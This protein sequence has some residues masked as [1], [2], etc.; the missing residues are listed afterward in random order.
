MNEKN[1]WE[2]YTSQRGAEAT[3]CPDP[4]ELA[5][6]ID[7]LLDPEARDAIEAHLSRC[8]LCLASVM[9][10][11]TH[12]STNPTDPIPMEALTAAQNLVIASPQPV[13]RLWHGM[14]GVAAA[15]LFVVVSLASYQTGQSTYKSSDAVLMALLDEEIAPFSDAL[16]NEPLP[17]FGVQRRGGGS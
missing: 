2:T 6:Y 1:I 17:I 8:D 14:Q 16:T 4:L 5:A 9:D 13:N 7:G 3:L 12:P 10:L 15:L 11:R